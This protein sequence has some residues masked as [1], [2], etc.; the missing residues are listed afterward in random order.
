VAAFAP[1]GAIA[2]IGTGQGSVAGEGGEFDVLAPVV[3]DVVPP[4]LRFGLVDVQG[5]GDLWPV[6]AVL[7]LDDHGR[8]QDAFGQFP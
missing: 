1:A 3:D 6:G 4:L 8:C 2:D 5:V 7:A